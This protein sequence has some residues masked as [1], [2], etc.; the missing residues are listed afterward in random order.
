MKRIYWDK[1]AQPIGVNLTQALYEMR[2]ED[3]DNQL[4]L[5]SVT[6]DEIM[7]DAE[8]TVSMDALVTP[9]SKLERRMTV[10]QAVMNRTG[11]DVKVLAMQVTQPFKNRGVTNVAAVFELSD[12]QTISV[13]FHNP[14]TTP[15][16]LAPT[17]EMISWKWLLNKKDVTIAVAPEQGKDLNIHEVARR[18][19]RLADRNSAAFARANKRRA[20]RL[21]AI[22]AAKN[23]VSQ[24]EE[25]LAGL[26]KDIEAARIEL[27]DKQSKR[28]IEKSAYETRKAERERMEA[29]RKAKEEAERL[30]AEE[31]ARQEEEQRKAAE[32]QAKREQEEEL[33]RQRNAEPQKPEDQTVPND[34]DLA[35]DMKVVQSII[36]K[37]HPKISSPDLFA[38]IEALWNRY[39]GKNDSMIDLLNKAIEA[40]SEVANDLT[41][42]VA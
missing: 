12:G 2:L 30:A 9:Y 38:D 8:E 34:L 14:D 19:M 18:L 26:Q 16:R 17:D 37:T 42:N 35:T 21:Q 24:L 13:Y 5:D 10:M 4:L 28:D 40:W 6:V 39:E 23:E 11:T 31:R 22:Q 33:E 41:K 36:D 29:E 7:Q 15:N 1:E 32:E 27:E 20:E 25:E 3:G